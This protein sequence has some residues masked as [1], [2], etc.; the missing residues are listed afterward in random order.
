MDLKETKSTVV[1]T[2]ISSEDGRNTY[3]IAK[4]LLKK[5][6]MTAV[7]IMIYPGTSYKNILKCDS[8]SQAVINHCEELGISK[9][10]LLNLT[11]VVTSS[12]LSTR[13]I[14]IDK[15]NIA[16]IEG[17]MKEE[18]AYLYE[19]I[20]AWGSSHSTSRVISKTKGQILLSLQKYLPKVKLKQFMVDGI[21]MQCEKGVHP[22]FLKIRYANATWYLQDYIIP[23]EI[24]DNSKKKKESKDEPKEDTSIKLV[25][26]VKKSSNSRY[27]VQEKF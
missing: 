17:I 26:K 20:I 13:N 19:W 9:V 25:D 21:D 27:I 18:N 5:N 7:V 2:I 10:R 16:Y 4:E 1:T 3:E 24:L 6:G 22:L 14:Q 11:S 12:R 15:E 8:T 23:K